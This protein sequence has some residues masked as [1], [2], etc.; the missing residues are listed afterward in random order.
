MDFCPSN[1]QTK[2][3]SFSAKIENEKENKIQFKCRPE[4]RMHDS[5]KCKW[6]KCQNV[7]WCQDLA[8]LTKSVAKFEKAGN[9]ILIDRDLHRKSSIFDS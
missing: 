8:N 4:N 9:C 1:L 5:L 2:S 7:F 6:N 3:L